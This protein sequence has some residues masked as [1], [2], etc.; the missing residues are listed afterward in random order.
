M[1][2]ERIALAKAVSKYEPYVKLF[3][4]GL[5]MVVLWGAFI[6]VNLVMA[7]ELTHI[8]Q[9]TMVAYLSMANAIYSRLVLVAFALV[10]GGFG[11]AIIIAFYRSNKLFRNGGPR[12]VLEVIVEM[13]YKY[14]ELLLRVIAFS[15]SLFLPTALSIEYGA[16]GASWW[17]LAFLYVLVAILL[18]CLAESIARLAVIGDS[19]VLFYRR[20]A[21]A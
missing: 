8:A 15:A 1:I 16:Y 19:S 3:Y 17:I 18:G 4:L 5:L 20:G 13:I 2:D 21:V 11:G 7:A 6:M 14:D 12:A 9:N 10:A